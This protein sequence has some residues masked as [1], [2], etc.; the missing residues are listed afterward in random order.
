[1]RP[2]RIERDVQDREIVCKGVN[3]VESLNLL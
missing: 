1:M 3:L 2:H